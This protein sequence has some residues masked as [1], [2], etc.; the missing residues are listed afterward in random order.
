M[1]NLLNRKAYTHRIGRTARAGQTGMAL[2]FVIPKELYRKHPPTSTPSCEFDE[3]VLAH[4]TE[5]QKKQGHEVQNYNFDM[6][7]LEGFRYRI[8]DALRSVTKIAV[9]KA[10]TQELRDALINSERLQRYFEENPLEKNYLRRDGETRAIRSRP[11]LKH[12]PDYLLPN[13]AN[14]N[15][16]SQDA[17]F[18]GFRSGSS[19][20]IRA[21]RARNKRHGKG[22]KQYSGRKADPLKS[23]NAKGRKQG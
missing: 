20:R 4:I 9:R 5:D 2:S 7:R 23:F 17:P 11:H 15:I 19:N 12:V 13:G 21:A 3:E 6:K 8:A 1:T 10:R 16:L 14:Q 18:V 22:T